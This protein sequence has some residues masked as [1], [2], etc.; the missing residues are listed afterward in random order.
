MIRH[1]QLVYFCILSMLIAC[2]FIAGCADPPTDQTT[3]STWTTY[4]DKAD[5]FK[6]SHPSDWSLT[7]TKTAPMTIRDPS[8]PYLTMEDV[9]HIYSPDTKAA[10][11]IMGFAYPPPLYSDDGITDEAY[12]LLVNAISSSKENAK[13]LSIVR[14]EDSYILNGNSA[15]HLQATIPLNNKATFTDNYIVR[16][17]KVYYIITYVMYESSAEKYSSTAME[18]IKTFKTAE[19]ST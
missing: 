6:I 15:R 3:K 18:I 5:G 12:D 7:V 9:V 8:L 2:V 13:P 4:G 16:H 1:K 17:D 19:W 11:N 10:V 14:D